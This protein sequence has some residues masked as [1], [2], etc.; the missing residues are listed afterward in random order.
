MSPDRV[1]TLVVLVLSIFMILGSASLS[2]LQ[3][4]IDN[5]SAEIIRAANSNIQQLKA[6]RQLAA[7]N[8]EEDSSDE[9]EEE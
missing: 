7:E 8:S 2:Y 9:S 6:V 5:T 4:G 1:M 3:V